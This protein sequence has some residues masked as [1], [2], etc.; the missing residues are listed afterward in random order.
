[1]QVGKHGN[2]QNSMMQVRGKLRHYPQ[3]KKR[4]QHWEK[5]NNCAMHSKH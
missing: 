3:H 1:V 2:T 5:M 4:L